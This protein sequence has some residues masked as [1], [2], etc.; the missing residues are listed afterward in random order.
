MNIKNNK[1]QEEFWLLTMVDDKNKQR[2]QLIEEPEEK[3]AR[4]E[5]KKYVE[6][7][8]KDF[9]IKDWYLRPQSYWANKQ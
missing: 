4:I 2:H 9:K 3:D 1:Q 6:Y 7:Y 8:G 5:A